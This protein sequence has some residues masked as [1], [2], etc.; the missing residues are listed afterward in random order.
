[1]ARLDVYALEAYGLFKVC[2]VFFMPGFPLSL[3]AWSNRVMACGWLERLWGVGHSSG[4]T[5]SRAGRMHHHTA[6]RCVELGTSTPLSVAI[7][8]HCALAHQV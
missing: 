8:R 3:R 6:S 4:I 1:M 5:W 2:F 7:R